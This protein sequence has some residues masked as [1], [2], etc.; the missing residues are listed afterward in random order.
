[1]TVMA[2]C[3]LSKIRLRRLF[4]ASV[5]LL[6]TLALAHERLQPQRRSA[7]PSLLASARAPG[8]LTRPAMSPPPLP[9]F[10]FKRA[11]RGRRSGLTPVHVV[12]G[13]VN[14]YSV[15]QCWEYFRFR[16]EDMPQ[17]L[18]KRN[19]PTVGGWVSVAGSFE[20][21]RPDASPRA[22]AFVAGV[23]RGCRGREAQQAYGHPDGGPVRAPRAHG[24][25]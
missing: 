18:H 1:M 15:E 24:L 9:C 21:R 3:A 16:K 12:Q 19:I 10:S 22:P 17:L 14:M 11:C 5:F 4:H 8:D 23:D 20:P 6:G 2:L 25:P 13:R 7:F